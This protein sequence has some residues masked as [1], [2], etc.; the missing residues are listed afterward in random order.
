MTKVAQR[1]DSIKKTCTECGE[2]KPIGEYS[3][4]HIS[5]RPMHMCRECFKAKCATNAAKAR[6]AKAEKAAAQEPK[7]TTPKKRKQRGAKGPI[8]REEMGTLVTLLRVV[9]TSTLQEMSSVLDS[10][11]KRTNSVV[12]HLEENRIIK[13]HE[14]NFKMAGGSKKTVVRYSLDNTLRNALDVLA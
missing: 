12:R 1:L 9:N 2:E 13:K 7:K 5:K 11:V 6:K 10:T 14:H 8:T 3:I 4:H